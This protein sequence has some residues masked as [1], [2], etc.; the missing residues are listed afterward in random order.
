MRIVYV[1]GKVKIS[2]IEE[3]MKAIKKHWPQPIEIDKRWIPFLVEDI[4]TVNLDAWMDEL[5]TKEQDDDTESTIS[6]PK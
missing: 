5:K 4:A 6:T 3:E 2:L 1:D